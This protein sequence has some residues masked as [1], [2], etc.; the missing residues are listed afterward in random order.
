MK[1]AIYARKS[2]LSDKGESIQNQIDMCKSYI[3]MHYSE[4][5]NNIEIYKDEGFSGGNTKRPD[6]IRLIN[7]CREKK[8]KKLICYRL[9]RVSRSIADF[10][11]TYT[12]LEMHEIE[13][14]S[15]KENFDTSTPIGRAMLNIALVFAQ[16]ERETIQ[17]RIRDNLLSLA[18][19][20]KWLGGTTPL[21]YE[22]Q[23]VTYIG[24]NNKEKHSYELVVKEDER[25]TVE[26]IFNKYNELGTIS[27]IETYLITEN[28]RTRKNKTFQPNTIREILINPTYCPTSVE[29]YEYFEAL[30]CKLTFTKAACNDDFCF[31]PFNRCKNGKRN[32]SN[33][34]KDWILAQGT[35]KPI[36]SADLWL[37]AQ[38]I[39]KSNSSMQLKWHNS[40]ISQVALLSG[41]I[42]C[43]CGA[44]M[45]V[46]NQA[47]LVDGTISYIYKC[48]DK[49]RS[50]GKLCNVQ[51]IKGHY[52]DKFIVDKISAMSN[53]KILYEELKNHN[54]EVFS[55]E[56]VKSPLLSIET[57]IKSN[58]SKIDNL[59]DNLAITKEEIMRELLLTKIN[60]LQ[61][62][63]INLNNKL[64]SM[65]SKISESNN[66]PEHIF[67]FSNV[68]SN[69]TDNFKK[70]TFAQK[71]RLINNLLADILFD[72]K[73]IRV[74]M[75][76]NMH[77]YRSQYEGGK[78]FD[79]KR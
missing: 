5:I 60:E 63:N 74:T 10:S 35:H 14:V 61:I 22:S 58:K 53:P 2:R 1:I 3:A 26:T 4:D 62:I 30:G 19:G 20:G 23:K 41:M 77:D 38:Q 43:K 25:H 49:V 7:D 57:E 71:K 55:D 12:V 79:E 21:G 54:N 69:F 28:I 78:I 67:Q 9:D 18:T 66:I 33:D 75:Y 15:I 40:Q 72:G 13:F 59:V 31:L 47:T 32:Q 27:K 46:T 52:L 64:E 11:S 48:A 6:F 76:N 37:L 45:K 39:I 24:D 29:A 68:L 17:E 56:F 70:S 73:E 34:Y 42:N 51:N 44:R 8:V 36:I 16:L 50:R 65:K